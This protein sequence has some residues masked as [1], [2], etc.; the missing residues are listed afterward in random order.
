MTAMTCLRTRGVSRALA[1]MLASLLLLVGCTGDPEE[2][3]PSAMSDVELPGW[4]TE[5]SPLPGAEAAPTDIIEVQHEQRGDLS[6]VRILIDGVDVTAV[7]VPREGSNTQDPIGESREEPY[8]AGG[9]LT[10]D[11]N[12]EVAPVEIQPG[13]HTV[14]LEQVRQPEEGAD[15]EVLDT[16]EWTFTVR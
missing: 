8:D 11:P 4:V 13:E 15:F 6:G 10:Y 14:T 7:A 12:T 9:L 16:F 1:L 3:D 2:S 5:V